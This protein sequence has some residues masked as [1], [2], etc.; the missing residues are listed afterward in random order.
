M[1]SARNF[2]KLCF[3][4]SRSDSEMLDFWQLKLTFHYKQCQ[5]ACW[6]CNFSASDKWHKAPLTLFLFLDHRND[7]NSYSL[8]FVPPPLSLWKINTW[9]L[10][11]HFAEWFP[12]FL[13]FNGYTMVTVFH[14]LPYAARECLSA[15]V[16]IIKPS[17]RQ[18]CFWP[19]PC[20]CTVCCYCLWFATGSLLPS[21]QQWQRGEKGEAALPCLLGA[22]A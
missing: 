18:P 19:Q 7:L 4:V 21:H 14:Q 2:H 8:S 10:K 22:G 12:A 5:E 20:C 3:R 16:N 15:S 13:S 11:I 1:W 6:C 17:C 9:N